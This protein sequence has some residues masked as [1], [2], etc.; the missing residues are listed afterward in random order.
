MGRLSPRAKDAGLAGLA[1]AISLAVYVRT[2]YPGLNGIGDT[3]KFQFVGAIL[4]TPHPPGY[5][6]YT[7]LGWLFSRLPFGNLAWRIN[8]LS[9]VSASLAVALLYLLVRRLGGS[10]SAAFASALAFAFGPVFWSQATLAEVYT[11]AAALLSGLLLATVAW[12]SGDRRGRG[13][14][15][16]VF[17]AA[18]AMA[19]HT[20]V[21][22]VVP[23]LVLY[24]LATD[25][26]AALAPGFLLR[27]GLLVALGLA[28]YLLVL[29]R[30]RQG[31]A[32]LGARARSLGELWDVMRGA[33]FEGRL[34][35]FDLA[36]MVSDRS[37]IVFDILRRELGLLGLLLAALG[38]F[39]LARHARREALL[40][41]L[42]VAGLLVFALGYDVPDIDVFLVASFVP[43]WAL[44]GVGLE[45]ALRA[46]PT[47]LPR[48]LVA[49]LAL[50]WPASQA[51]LHFRASDHSARSFEMR[52]FAALFETL[53][54]HAAIAAESY[55][56]DH[57][58]LYELLGERA[59]RGRDI[60]ALPGDAE[61]VSAAAGKGAR[62]FAFER[63]VGA[64]R[65]QGFRFTPVRLPGEELPAHLRSLPPAR[66]VL[67][68]GR[69]GAARLAAIGTP[70]EPEAHARHGDAAA[71]DVAAGAPVGP[72]Q[73]P[74]ELRA[75]VGDGAAV[76]A[77][78][79]RILRSDDGLAF[80]VLGPGGRVL[81]AHALD[82]T[83]R[84]PLDDRPFPLYRLVGL[85]EC[86]DFGDGE[87]TDVASATASGR[88]LL[89][90]D[91][92]APFQARVVLWLFG[93]AAFA[94]RLARLEGHGQPAVDVRLFLPRDAG[95]R[96]ARLAD[97]LVAEV[98]DGHA[99]RVELSVDDGGQFSAAT[100]DL[101][102]VARS[103]WARA[104]VDLR[105]PKRAQ[106]C[107]LVPGDRDPASPEI[108][109]ALDSEAAAFLGAGWHD[110]EPAGFRWT[111]A[112]QAELWVPV[113]AVKRLRVRLRAMPLA[114]SGVP[115]A[116]LSVALN[117]VTLGSRAM[118]PGFARYEF[119]AEGAALRAGTSR[120]SLRV[121]AARRP[122]DLGLG[123]DDRQ[124]GVAV[125]DL[126]V[127]GE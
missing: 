65:S 51:A 36:A 114:G 98:G 1:F 3:P 122:R 46:A 50:A 84:V 63:T 120:L 73:A 87:W 78:G 22:M 62:V 95:L 53:P 80:A 61:S 99:A 116:T 89:R 31:A 56:I 105:N 77:A 19:H 81:E 74:S 12:G 5:P 49:G 37:A 71:V 39:A 96:P 68:A 117:G 16:A 10:G 112:A 57:M 88:L 127:R 70:A 97:G 24:V 86:R 34:F 41:G 103:A 15:L 2:L 38:L 28:P 27:G 30:N 64:L 29:L 108:G 25:R 26:R 104:Q 40:L 8:L 23:A 17:L 7:L 92:H 44:A 85:P 110:P 111:A 109:F 52:Y 58:V 14:A 126:L 35:A 18:L 107:A 100:F 11:L 59:A 101:G 13:P 115:P 21:A 32:Y 113:A 55:T 67:Q 6:V 125:S 33:S 106:A 93:E 90:V 47:G 75:E 94:P 83:L 43:L 72:L 76:W 102:G 124:L 42:A 91:N 4:G 48:V 9:A 118:V 20:T 45:R 79:V 60:R 119:E 69:R 123:A 121:E 82:A 54:D 66:V